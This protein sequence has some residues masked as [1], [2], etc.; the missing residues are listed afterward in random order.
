MVDKVL[1]D[2]GLLLELMREQGH[3]DEQIAFEPVMYMDKLIGGFNLRILM[4]YE[5][6]V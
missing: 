4:L 2:L 3:V 1:H 6:P 5:I